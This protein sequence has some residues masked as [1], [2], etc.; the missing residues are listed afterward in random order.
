MSDNTTLNTGTGGDVIRDIDRGTG[1]K[2][3]VV[4]LDFG[5]ASTNAEQLVSS[6]NPLPVNVFRIIDLLEALLIETRVNNQ[7][8]ASLGQAQPD[9]PDKLRG[10]LSHATLMQ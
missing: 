6:S 9:D 3:Q 7:L 4:Q 8:L 10:D 1:S 5:G 2:T